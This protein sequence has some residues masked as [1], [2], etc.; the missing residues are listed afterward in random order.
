MHTFWTPWISVYEFAYR[1]FIK[2]SDGARTSVCESPRVHPIHDKSICIELTKRERGGMELLPLLAQ[3]LFRLLARSLI[4][5]DG[6]IS[7]PSSCSSYFM[8]KTSRVQQLSL[9]SSTQWRPIKIDSIR[10][11]WEKIKS[12]DSHFLNVFYNFFH[13]RPFV[14]VNQLYVSF[15]LPQKSILRGLHFFF[16]LEFEN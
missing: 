2:R 1:N 16:Y 9:F 3:V 7:S 4:S 12:N 5:S 6:N 10:R 14:A 11:I 15:K 13:W 8:V